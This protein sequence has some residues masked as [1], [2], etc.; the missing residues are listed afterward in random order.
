MLKN[1]EWLSSP[2]VMKYFLL[3]ARGSYKN[4]HKFVVSFPVRWWSGFSHWTCCLWNIVYICVTWPN[5][6]SFHLCIKSLSNW[7][8]LHSNWIKWKVLFPL[9]IKQKSLKKWLFI[10]SIF[11][12]EDTQE[13]CLNVMAHFMLFS[14]NY[15]DIKFSQIKKP[16]NL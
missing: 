7:I 14:R 6:T 9:I 11:I 10:Y 13:L 1:V 2:M 4:S 8:K 15:T 12:H 3:P 16:P 5:S